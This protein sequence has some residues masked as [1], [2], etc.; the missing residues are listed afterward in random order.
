MAGKHLAA[1]IASLRSPASLDQR[2]ETLTPVL[3]DP[4]H[5]TRYEREIAGAMTD[6]YIRN[7]AITGG[8]GSGKSS[9]IRTFKENNPGFTYATVSLATF[10][11]DGVVNE[12]AG[13]LASQSDELRG[14][15]Q[16]SLGPEQVGALVERIEETIVQQLLYVVPASKLP[17]TRLKRITQPS[18]ARSWSVTLAL[19][20]AAVAGTH[21][22]LV[23]RAEPLTVGAQW[24]ANKLS[25]IQIPWAIAVVTAVAAG[26]LYQIVRSLSLLN[27]DGW[28]IKGG[29]IESMQHSSVLHK[30]VDELLYCFQNSEIDVVVI[31]DLDRFGIQDVFFRLREIN[32]IINE[33]PQIARTI[34]FIYALNDELFAGS[35]KTKFFDLILPVVPVINK[36]NSHA[37]MIELLARRRLKGK[38]LSAGID[39]ELVETVS[40]RIDDMRLVKNIVNE[41]DV[42]A[43]I[44]TREL[45]LP[46]SKLF[47]MIVV[48]NLHSDEYW[49]LA[50]RTGFLYRLISGYTTWRS[51]RADALRS[52][53]AN[54]EQLI[55][56]KQKE[57]ARSRRELRLLAWHAAQADVS[58]ATHIR[59]QHTNYTL[60][61]FLED[62]AFH[63]LSEAK[64]LRFMRDSN[65]VGGAFSLAS[66]LSDMDYERR[67]NAIEVSD[68]ELQIDILSK[69]NQLRDLQKLPLSQALLDGYQDVYA[70]ELG[71]YETI[72]YLL[73]A[74]HLDED[75]ADYLGHFYG[76]AIGRED[77]NLIFTLRQGEDCGVDANIKDPE[78]FL[79]KLRLRNIDR[80]RGIIAELL[81]YLAQ[82]HQRGPGHT[83]AE[84]LE[85]IFDDVYAH[86]ARFALA[87]DMLVQ[88]QSEGALIQAMYD[89]RPATISAV[90]TASIDPA[91]PPKPSRVVAV[92]KALQANQLKAIDVMDSGFK[93][94]IESTPDASSLV[95]DVTRESDAWMWMKSSGVR[96][97]SLAADTCPEVMAA[98][99]EQDVL[100]PI[101]PML[102]LV[103]LNGGPVEQQV[104]PVTLSRLHAADRFS[105][106][107][108]F[109][110]DHL[111][112]IVRELLNQETSLIEG[113]DVAL[114]TLTIIQ[115]DED[116]ALQFF[117]A[118][119]CSFSTLAELAPHLWD[120]AMRGD[121][122][123]ERADAIRSYIKSRVHWATDPSECEEQEIA[124]SVLADYAN[125]H[126]KAIADK[127]WTG[128]DSVD[129]LQ[130]WIV[131]ERELTDDTVLTLSSAT[132]ITSVTVLDE[133]AS[134]NR[135]QLLARN[136]RLAALDDIWQVIRNR[137]IEVQ[138]SYL[139]S[140]WGKFR[141]L[142]DEPQFDFQVALRLYQMNIL[143][144]DESLRIFAD[145]DQTELAVEREVIGSL[146]QWAL[147]EDQ[148]FP[149][150]LM[151]VAE[152]ILQTEGVHQPWTISL[153][154]AA[155]PAMGWPS[156]A[157]A[158]HTLGADF[159]K[160]SEGKSAEVTPTDEAKPVL[161]ALKRNGF[162]STLTPGRKGKIRVNMKKNLA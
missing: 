100:A 1:A 64:N 97:D 5:S 40:Y 130:E 90:L 11:K 50:K 79:R 86:L 158:L 155:M 95:S 126:A 20:L 93:R 52:E 3:L 13:D 147:A 112:E 129:I 83:Y 105:S 123:V 133:S 43:E 19:S 85:R 60:D 139:G 38:A 138:A 144:F 127:L 28:S 104:Q 132:I 150:S 78:K 145:M 58:G 111:V 67:Y 75:Y 148:K 149:P 54:V 146:A 124:R 117:E 24:L 9:L 94:R 151:A 70:T 74:G 143:S 37:K 48:K 7:I 99:I 59:M 114:A 16:N 82:V 80:G 23:T 156:V 46:L 135:I 161:D 77:M 119:T 152:Q 108:R 56:Q 84:F 141:L 92:L 33:S 88:Q 68:T 87:F 109:V 30:N 153:L 66:A 10:R 47:A 34:R 96:F 116:L 25:W 45:P 22:F 32:A 121:R 142:A 53:I 57:V 4:A 2:L 106:V 128:E 115:D 63:I 103:A 31:E 131:R 159:V 91:D 21:L 69:Q 157:R 27:I 72:R 110:S 107:R 18:R 42:F 118:T 101:L 134:D 76:H 81:L 29:T 160:L 15:D 62:D 120:S 162:A 65:Y 71:Q 122:V 26:V 49:K 61:Q 136:G 51:I 36:E 98:L 89:L 12:S 39:D 140:V 41:L 14:S 17:R 35:D 154:V 55:G 113:P 102:R 73:V 44:L 6:P 125:V 8:Y 137:G